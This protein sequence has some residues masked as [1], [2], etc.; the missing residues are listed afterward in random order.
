MVNEVRVRNDG[1]ISGVSL[2]GCT[3]LPAVNFR[4]E[5]GGFVKELGEERKRRDRSTGEKTKKNNKI[6][7]ELEK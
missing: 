2:V 5:S 6:K 3:F 4:H 1:W 7:L